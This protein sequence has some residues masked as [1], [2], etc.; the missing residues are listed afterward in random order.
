MSKSLRN[1]LSIKILSYI[2]FT[3]VTKLPML[4]IFVRRVDMFSFWPDMVMTNFKKHTPKNLN[5]LIIIECSL[6]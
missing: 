5:K 4:I 1:K 3:V 2:D 6:N